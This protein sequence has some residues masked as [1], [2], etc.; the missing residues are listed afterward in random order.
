MLFVL[1]GCCCGKP[2]SGVGAFPRPCWFQI[3]WAQKVV[4]EGAALF[5]VGTRGRTVSQSESSSRSEEFQE[6]SCQISSCIVVVKASPWELTA[7]LFFFF[8]FLQVLGVNEARSCLEQIM[9]IDSIP[10][11]LG[12]P[13]WRDPLPLVKCH[14]MQE[15]PESSTFE[16]GYLSLN[17]GSLAKSANPEEG[18]VASTAEPG[19]PSSSEHLRSSEQDQVEMQLKVDFFRKLGYSSEEILIVLQKLGLNA[20]TNT[21]LGEL[22]KHGMAVAERDATDMLQEAVKTVLVPRGGVAN[23]S[24]MPVTTPKGKEGENLRP[25]VVDGS[26][27]AMRYDF[28]T[29]PSPIGDVS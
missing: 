3:S 13:D 22:V 6:C 5:V 15:E 26:N 1:V 27:V 24:P 18:Y 21:V 25:I 19:P 16:S 29:P 8:F 23:T 11:A 20:D 17:T 28:V 10:T 14:N 2:S 7:T 9:N 12:F 4:F